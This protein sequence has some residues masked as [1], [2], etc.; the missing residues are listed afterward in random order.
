MNPR[1]LR[2]TRPA[3]EAKLLAQPGAAFLYIKLG[4][5]NQTGRLFPDGRLRSNWA[6]GPGTGP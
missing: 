4:L 6:V 2:R 5:Y 1:E 3:L